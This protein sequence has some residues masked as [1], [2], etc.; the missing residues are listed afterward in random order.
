MGVI[1]LERARRPCRRRRRYPED[2]LR[3]LRGGAQP[4]R[5]GVLRLC[6]GEHPGAGHRILERPLPANRTQL[7]H[8]Q[9]LF[10]GPD[11]PRNPLRRLR[12]N[13]Q[14]NHQPL[15]A[16]GCA[17][18]QSPPGCRSRRSG[19]PGVPPAHPNRYQTLRG[20]RQPGNPA[21]DILLRFLR[22]YL[23]RQRLRR[24]HHRYG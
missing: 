9:L 2:H 16:S 3:L 11:D 14:R 10:Q 6:I 23:G 24:H 13:L 5:T 12:E 4:P 15:R 21:P 19:Y 1:R 20:R 18:K 7:P 8:R 17:A 22:Q